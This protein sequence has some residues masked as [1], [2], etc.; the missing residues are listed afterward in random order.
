MT[1]CVNFYREVMT[2]LI[3]PTTKSLVTSVE[4]VTE[5]LVLLR[6][7][8]TRRVHNP[9]GDS[10]VQ[11]FTFS[12]SRGP[13]AHDP[14]FSGKSPCHPVFHKC[15]CRSPSTRCG[16]CRRDE[17]SPSGYGIVKLWYSY[18]SI[19]CS[20]IRGK[21]LSTDENANRDKKGGEGDNNRLSYISKVNFSRSSY[22]F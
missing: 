3:T 21:G 17:G 8:V 12:C 13:R 18:T 11:R 15:T 14:S 1:T 2:C 6:G 16:V 10:C 7:H 5:A 20:G 9:F 19:R 4:N 22:F